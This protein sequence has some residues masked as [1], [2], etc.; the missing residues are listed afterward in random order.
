MLNQAT[1]IQSDQFDVSNTIHCGEKNVCCATLVKTLGCIY[2]CSM[3]VCVAY[4]KIEVT[5]VF[6]PSP[7]SDAVYQVKCCCE[8]SVRKFSYYG[9]LKMIDSLSEK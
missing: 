9:E 8:M 2:T 1:S 6:F 5:L 3:D 7:Q 4:K